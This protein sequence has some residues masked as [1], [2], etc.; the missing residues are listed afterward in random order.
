MT[1]I[2]REKA[3]HAVESVGEMFRRAPDD[4][5]FVRAMEE[6]GRKNTWFTRDNVLYAARQWGEALTGPNLARWTG[7]YPLAAKKKDVL[8]VLAGNIPLVGL[9]DILCHDKTVEG[10]YGAYLVRY[11]FFTGGRTLVGG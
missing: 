1:S 5:P 3:L 8:L 4:E 2:E 6:A 7:K 9:H 10:R 11:G